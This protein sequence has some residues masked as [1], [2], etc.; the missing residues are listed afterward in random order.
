MSKGKNF[1]LQRCSSL[2]DSPSRRKQREDDREH[3][4]EMLQPRLSTFNQFS[5][6]GV[7]SRDKDRELIQHL[8][9]WNRPA[10]IKLST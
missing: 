6:N 1:N 5:Q 4:V 9:A 2:K 10:A 8:R 3:V 7:F